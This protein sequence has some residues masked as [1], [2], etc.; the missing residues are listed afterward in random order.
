MLHWRSLRSKKDTKIDINYSVTYIFY[1]NYQSLRF[2]YQSVAPN[3]LLGSH[4]LIKFVTSNGIWEQTL[5][6]YCYYVFLDNKSHHGRV[7][8]RYR[9]YSADKVNLK[10]RPESFSIF[11]IT[12]LYSIANLIRDP[13]QLNL[14]HVTWLSK[15]QF[16]NIHRTRAA[17]TLTFITIL[18]IVSD[19]CDQRWFINQLSKNSI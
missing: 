10:G 14:N 6:V 3:T 2:R 18:L 5:D 4:P 19:I 12:L 11:F 7:R 15:S 13:N 9:Q 17:R 16:A 1:V 8:R